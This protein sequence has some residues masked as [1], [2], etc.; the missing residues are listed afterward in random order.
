[1]QNWPVQRQEFSITRSNA[2]R[3]DDAVKA[4]LN[5]RLGRAEK[6]FRQIVKTTP[7]NPDALHLL[8][9]IAFQKGH[10]K[11]AERR[12]RQAIK[13]RATNPAYHSN[14]GLVL[15][16]M[17]R[18]AEAADAFNQALALEADY[19][20]GLANLGVTLIDLKRYADAEAIYG[21]LLT[22]EP[23]SI[24]GLFGSANALLGQDKISD[25]IAAY[26]R[27]LEVA[28]THLEALSN[29]ANAYRRSGDLQ[30]AIALLERAEALAPDNADIL[31]QHGNALSDA[32]K[33][34][35]AAAGYRRALAAVPD[36]RAALLNLAGLARR[37]GDGATAEAYCTR[38]LATNADD[39]DAHAE[40]AMQHEDGHRLE[41]AAVAAERALALDPSNGSA[42]RVIARLARRGGDL[43]QAANRLT[44]FLQKQTD[45]EADIELGHIL[46]RLDRPAAAFAAFLRGNRGLAADKTAMRYDGSTYLLE[47]ARLQAYFSTASVAD[48]PSQPPHDN[49]PAPIFF[50]AFPRSG[51]TLM[52][53]ILDA[54]PAV[55]TTGEASLLTN[56]TQL[57]KSMNSQGLGYPEG[58]A[59]LDDADLSTL[60][61]AYWQAVE[62]WHGGQLSDR[63]LVDKLPLNLLHLGLV[64]RLF[65]D[66]KILLALRDPRD[67]VLSCFMQTFELNTAM[68]HFLDLGDA[69]RLYCAVMELASVYRQRLDLDLMAY[70]YED[71]VADPEATARKVLS[72]LGLAWDDGVMRY[73]ERLPSRAVATPSYQDVTQP[74]YNRAVGRW[75]AYHDEMA[76]VLDILLPVTTALGYDAI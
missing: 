17:G 46:D 41:A 26:E 58:L 62:E 5:G 50:V 2:S 42:M 21:R 54:H 25:S 63:N 67:V 65:P 13:I 69:A 9:L 43:E 40:F 30:S 60:R 73:Y 32:Q 49:L 16:D 1:V 64:K 28:P 66:A 75:R 51:T 47:I 33:F 14:L 24:D 57:V 19:I 3:F 38:L 71:L 18:L 55:T 22:L 29:L 76:E 56:V 72:H 48:W 53:Q 35:A 44:Q 37:E 59:G 23:T 15:R 61:Q 74:V 31:I 6:L 52:E 20:T 39:S 11:D 34:T 12:I 8:G 45:H 27:V 70:R 68:V 7:A 36:H 4:Y 10:A